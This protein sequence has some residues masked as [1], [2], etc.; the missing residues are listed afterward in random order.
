MNDWLKDVI[1]TL[2]TL[3]RDMRLAQFLGAHH[4]G[5]LRDVAGAAKIKGRSKMNIRELRKAIAKFHT[6]VGLG[7]LLEADQ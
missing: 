3:P 2:S 6:D 7:T 1:H 5:F 4:I